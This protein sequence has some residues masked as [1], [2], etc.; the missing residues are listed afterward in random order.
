MKYI[1]LIVSLILYI[2][3]DTQNVYKTPSGRKYHLSSCRMVEN[4]YRKLLGEKE[5]SKYYLSPCK[6]CKPSLVLINKDDSSNK[7]VGTSSS[8][9]CKGYTKQGTRCKHMTRLS[10]GYCYQHTERNSSLSIKYSGYSNG[11]IST[12]G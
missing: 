5:I 7:T 9:R 2:N 3:T 10:N 4:V 11:S 6:I 1:I 8:V 12:C